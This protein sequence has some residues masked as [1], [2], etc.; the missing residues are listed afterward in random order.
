MNAQDNL[1]MTTLTS[2]IAALL[3]ALFL[4]TGAAT[5]DDGHDHGAPSAATGPASPRFAAVSETFELV[6]VLEGRQLTLYLDRFADNSPVKGAQ[7]D[8]EI[9]GVKLKA[10][11]HGEGEFEALLAEAP[12]AGVLSIAATIVAGEESDLLAGELDIHEEAHAD[13]A[14]A[15]R[16]RWQRI[17]VG[18]LG[19]LFALGVIVWIARRPRLGGVA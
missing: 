16:P 3:P 12:K 18:A 17:A 5:A 19:A 7:I 14:G 1:F 4:M 9:D 15:A 8:L 11:P 10:E 6:G 13:A 2:R